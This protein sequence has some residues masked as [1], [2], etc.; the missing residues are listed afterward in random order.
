M[1]RKSRRLAQ[2]VG[3]RCERVSDSTYTWC[4]ANHAVLNACSANPKQKSSPLIIWS[5]DETD[6]VILYIV[7]II[8]YSR[9][10][11]LRY[12]GMGILEKVGFLK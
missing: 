3:D 5:L 8:R 9:L 12:R 4:M 6:K 2:Q 1:D 10:P 11:L 7:Q